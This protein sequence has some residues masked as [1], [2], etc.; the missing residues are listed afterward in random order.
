MAF[1]HAGQQLV[2]SLKQPT[3]SLKNKHIITAI[4]IDYS[5]AFDVVSHPKL[6][7]KLSAYGISGN[8][9]TWIRQLLTGRTQNTRV[10]NSLS[11]SVQLGSGV[12]QGSC[13]GPL[14]FLLY[15]N[16]VTSV[17]SDKC[18]RKLYVDDLKLYSEITMAGDCHALQVIVDKVK[19]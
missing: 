12:V 15:V 7:H 2:T 11:D 10:G 13:L 18:K 8:L 17:I 6:F 14:L 9:L 5:K 1:C 3:V 4:Y 16:D 19:L